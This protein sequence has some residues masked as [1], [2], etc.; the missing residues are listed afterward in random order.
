MKTK[1]NPIWINL[2]VSFIVFCV[3]FLVL[4]Q[5]RSVDKY[6]AIIYSIIGGA[7]LFLILTARVKRSS[8]K[9]NK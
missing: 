4:R 9:K 2:A 8:K 7:I 6:E 3:A 1:T 5:I